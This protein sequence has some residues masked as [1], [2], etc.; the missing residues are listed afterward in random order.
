MRKTLVAGALAL[1]ATVA[2]A[3]T[4]SARDINHDRIPDRWERAFHLSLKVDQSKRDQDRDG[5]K[6]RAEWL[7]H[8]S[9][10]SVD[11][12]HDGVTD[13]REDANHDGVP[14][15]D[16]QRPPESHTESHTETPPAE[17]TPGDGSVAPPPSDDHP[18]GDHPAGGSVAS[19]E[20][21]PGFGGY[22]V[23]ERL[24]GEHVTAY[25]GEKTD[26][27]CAPAADAVFAPCSKEHLVP[28]TVVASA[29][30]GSNGH[31]DVWTRVY[32]IVPEAA[33]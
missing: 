9:P 32:L 1:A 25:F 29:E 15:G 4:A 20:Q 16:E 27:E 19:Y 31:A 22:L 14:N 23:I 18:V 5:L 30:H 8:T 24:N 17:S 26:L 33:R 3:A 7:D 10:R 28:G 21:S 6:N 11:T 12:D 2:P 13:G